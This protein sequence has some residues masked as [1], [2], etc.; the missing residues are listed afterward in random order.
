MTFHL[1]TNSGKKISIL[2]DDAHVEK[3][4][5]PEHPQECGTQQPQQQTT[6]QPTPSPRVHQYPVHP[7]Y[8]YH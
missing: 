3:K 7:Y 4:I 2:N 8:Y 6:Q 5:K 1:T